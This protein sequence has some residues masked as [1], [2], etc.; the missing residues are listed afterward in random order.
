MHGCELV[1]LLLVMWYCNWL[2]DSRGELISALRG[3]LGCVCALYARVCVCVARE[4]ELIIRFVHSR[5][6]TR[7]RTGYQGSEELGLSKSF[8]ERTKVNKEYIE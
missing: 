1:T 4:K 7:R 5:G 3:S 6:K 8:Q 2:P